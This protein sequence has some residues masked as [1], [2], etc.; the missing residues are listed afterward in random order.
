GTGED[1]AAAGIEVRIVLEYSHSRF[2]GIKTRSAA[3]QNFVTSS[4][5]PLQPRAIFTLLFR[6]HAAALNRS[7]AAVNHESKFLCFP[8]VLGSYFRCRFDRSVGILG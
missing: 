8:I 2:G 3:L 5:R 6:C 1:R 7:S 4:Q